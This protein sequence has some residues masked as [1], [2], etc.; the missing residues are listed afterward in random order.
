MIVTSKFP[1]VAVPD[2]SFATMMLEAFDRHG[3]AVAMVGSVDSKRL[4]FHKKRR[5]D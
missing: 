1:S 4:A 2:V 5:S 3:D